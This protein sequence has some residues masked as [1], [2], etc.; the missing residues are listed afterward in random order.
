MN[1]VKKLSIV[2]ALLGLGSL[3]LGF[4]SEG[5]NEKLI[6]A[7]IDERVDKRFAELTNKEE[8]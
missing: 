1:N 4:I 8:S 5:V 6:D 2:G 7:K 3:I